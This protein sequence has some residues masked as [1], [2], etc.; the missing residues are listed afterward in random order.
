LYSLVFVWGK[1]WTGVEK[2]KRNEAKT[3]AQDKHE[4]CMDVD[5][6]GAEKAIKKK[7]G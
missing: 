3:K 5:V 6:P 1:I 4:L 7:K 2:Q